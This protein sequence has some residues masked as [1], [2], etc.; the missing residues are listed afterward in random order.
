MSP[1]HSTVLLF[2][3]HHLNTDQRAQILL[4]LA[5]L[6]VEIDNTNMCTSLYTSR[7]TTLLH[8]LLAHFDHPSALLVRAMESLGIM[9]E[10]RND[11]N[12]V[13]TIESLVDIPFLAKIRPPP[14]GDSTKRLNYSFVTLDFF[15]SKKVSASS[16]AINILVKWEYDLFYSSLI[17]LTVCSNEESDS[18]EDRLSRSL[19]YL[20]LWSIVE[21][22]PVGLHWLSNV[23]NKVFLFGK[24]D[25][26]L[27]LNRDNLATSQSNAHLIHLFRIVYSNSLTN[28][29]KTDEEKH[30]ISRFNNVIEMISRDNTTEKESLVK[31]FKFFVDF[32]SVIFDLNES[33]IK[34]DLLNA[35]LDLLIYHLAKIHTCLSKSGESARQEFKSNRGFTSYF[36]LLVRLAREYKAFYKQQLLDVYFGQVKNELDTDLVS[37]VLNI[38][39]I[40]DSTS[41][42]I[43]SLPA[44]AKNQNNFNFLVNLNEVVA[45]SDSGFESVISFFRPII[46]FFQTSRSTDSSYAISSSTGP[47][48][49]LLKSTVA[50]ETA[51]IDISILVLL[52]SILNQFNTGLS[53]VTSDETLLSDVEDLFVEFNCDLNTMSIVRIGSEQILPFFNSISSEKSSIQRTRAHILSKVC[54]FTLNTIHKIIV[55]QATIECDEDKKRLL[56]SLC[57][58]MFSH[59]N[60]S[61]D[62]QIGVGSLIK[63]YESEKLVDL[64]SSYMNTLSES[65]ES[66]L[67]VFINKVIK[68][69]IASSNNIETIVNQIY[70]FLQLKDSF[71]RMIVGSL[72]SDDTNL[73]P[74]LRFKFEL[75]QLVL[76]LNQNVNNASASSTASHLLNVLIDIINSRLEDDKDLDLAELIQ[77]MDGLAS[78]SEQGHLI[79]LKASCNWLNKLHESI[80]S[81]HKEKPGEIN[82]KLFK[83]M[84][85]ILAYIS[86]LLS[87]SSSGVN[88]QL[89][90][91]MNDLE[92]TKSLSKLFTSQLT[93]DF[94]ANTLELLNSLQK[95]LKAVNDD[96]KKDNAQTP[97][98][99]K[100]KRNSLTIAKIKRKRRKTKDAKEVSLTITSIY[101]QFLTLFVS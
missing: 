84:S 17:N 46:E 31:Q 49:S 94:D 91:D 58:F 47:E 86:D 39:S 44:T 50:R 12:A 55:K 93:I 74:A 15:A 87:N 98:V 90:A 53:Q 64:L 28:E 32:W 21:M 51:R 82:E 11:A 83:T 7:L 13:I 68:H 4:K 6:V 30:I 80:Q 18:K 96:N 26:V 36:Q 69:S 57:S 45:S 78:A 71:S 95:Q 34:D 61:L 38:S 29:A 63:L 67:L 14:A 52:E 81:V 66:C 16:N 100:E 33:K 72:K 101:K 35:N 56:K 24:N 19:N 37:L 40:G 77:L 2:L 10:P 20:T 3:F 99:S 42:Q 92:S 85:Y 43:N 8:Y 65:P 5:G 97:P 88:S 62:T 9:S 89:I 1:E 25:D 59:V 60:R 22:L 54:R 79:L 73:L 75:N 23:M 41:H 27:D 76:L 70:S 48:H